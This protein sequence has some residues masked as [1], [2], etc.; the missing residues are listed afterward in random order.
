MTW[1]SDHIRARN[2][3]ILAAEAAAL[4]RGAPE[5]ERAEAPVRWDCEPP[6]PRHAEPK[7]IVRWECGPPPVPAW[8]V[9]LRLLTGRQIEDREAGG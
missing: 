8:L 1:A 5:R 3:R 6:W 4:V 9:A 2:A 7:D